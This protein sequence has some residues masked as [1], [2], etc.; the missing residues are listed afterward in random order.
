MHA[1]ILV[2]ND[3]KLQKAFKEDRLKGAPDFIDVK[4]FT[5]FDES[6]P[7]AKKMPGRALGMNFL[8]SHVRKAI[9]F[10]GNG[11]MPGPSA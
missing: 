8:R 9:E 4:K 1:L 10:V 2:Q 3:E 6:S 11:G 5:V 7:E